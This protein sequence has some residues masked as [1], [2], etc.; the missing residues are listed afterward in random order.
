[1]D[2]CEPTPEVT[3]GPAPIPVLTGYSGRTTFAPLSQGLRVLAPR[4][5]AP[6]RSG[7]LRHE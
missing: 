5:S 6:Q 3:T 4:I 2:A 7:G 1:M